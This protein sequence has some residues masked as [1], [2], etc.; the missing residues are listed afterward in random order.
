MRNMRGNCILKNK[1]KNYKFATENFFFFLIVY[2]V[3]STLRHT[4]KKNI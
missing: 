2:D 4:E 3:H 1:T